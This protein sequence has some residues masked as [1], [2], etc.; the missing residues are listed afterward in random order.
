MKRLLGVLAGVTLIGV[1]TTIS[2]T[3]YDWG[4]VAVGDPAPFIK[5]RVTLPAGFLLTD[6]VDV[7]LAGPDVQDFYVDTL[8]RVVCNMPDPWDPRRLRPGG[9]CEFQV[10]F[11]PRS[12]AAK[13]ARLEVVDKFGTKATATLHG[14]GIAPMCTMTVVFCN[15]AHL[16]SG[17]F[18]WQTGLSG[19]Y[20]QNSKTITVNVINGRANCSGSETDVNID[21][22][23]NRTTQV[24]TIL[25]PGLIAIEFEKD[26]TGKDVYR[27]TGACPS[28]Y[29][30][31]TADQPA[32]ASTPAELGSSYYEQSY[33]QPMPPG[34]TGSLVPNPAALRGGNT[35]PNPEAD[36]ANG[37]TG[38]IRVTWA[39]SRS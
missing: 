4:R 10:Q 13:T 20:G 5:F 30:P 8:G 1:A 2:P 17:S 14:F 39:F 15:Y 9:G 28:P 27:I 16:Y 23:G 33:Q 3:R 19:Q 31:P 29:W 22:R 24:G 37:V 12:V 35:Y 38:T 25:G 6:S 7:S 21:D 34:S 36:P 11:Q 26:S 32:R 18:S